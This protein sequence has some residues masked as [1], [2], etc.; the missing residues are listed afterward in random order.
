MI[1][2]QRHLG[3]HQPNLR[4]L[5]GPLRVAREVRGAKG[6][7]SQLLVLDRSGANST[8]AADVLNLR[9]LDYEKR[10]E[11]IMSSH[12]AVLRNAGPRFGCRKKQT[13]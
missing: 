1:Y 8:E 10:T 12:T 11:L 13:L 5:V 3:E 4:G 2:G 6:N 7:P 9:R